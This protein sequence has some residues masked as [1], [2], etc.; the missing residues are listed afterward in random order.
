MVPFSHG[1]WLCDHIPSSCRHLYP[2]HGHL[3]LAVDTFPT[4]LE[5]LVSR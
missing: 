1:G 2:E 5:E 3:T 4:I